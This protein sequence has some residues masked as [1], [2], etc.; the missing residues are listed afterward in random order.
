MKGKRISWILLGMALLVGVGVSGATAHAG[1]PPPEA[2]IVVPAGNDEDGRW[3]TGV[4]GAETVVPTGY[5]LEVGVE[6]VHNYGGSG[7]LPSSDDTARELYYMLGRAGWT[8]HRY[9]A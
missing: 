4:G 8:R 6:Y 3:K 5:S 9:R 1:D 7:N 2:E